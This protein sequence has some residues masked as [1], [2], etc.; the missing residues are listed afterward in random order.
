[1]GQEMLTGVALINIH[2]DTIISTDEIIDKFA[3]KHPRRLQF[4]SLLTEP[5]D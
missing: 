5:D 2:Y 1:M 4:R 3:K